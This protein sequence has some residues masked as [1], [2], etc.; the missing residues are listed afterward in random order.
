MWRLLLL[1]EATRSGCDTDCG[2]RRWPESASETFNENTSSPRSTALI[3][4]AAPTQELHSYLLGCITSFIRSSS[5][6]ERL[7]RP[8]WKAKAS[9][10][11]TGSTFCSRG[12]DRQLA[13]LPSEGD[14]L[15]TQ[16]ESSVRKQVAALRHV[17]TLSRIFPW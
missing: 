5:R 11:A 13:T 17:S 2:L 6:H 4:R 14:S 12:P 8:I 10:W 9:G 16:G 7:T 3:I 1:P 15:Q